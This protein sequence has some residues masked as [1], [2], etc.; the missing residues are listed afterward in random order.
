M[1][2]FKE[3]IE[4]TYEVLGKENISCLISL[5]NEIDGKPP[6]VNKKRYR[7][8]NPDQIPILDYLEQ[9]AHLITT[10]TIETNQFYHLRPYAIPLIKEQKAQKL[11]KLM[12]Q[13]YESFAVFYK[14]RLDASV[15]RDEILKAVNMP[16]E[17]ALEALSYF[18]DTHS[19]WGGWGKGFPY[20]EGSHIN[21]SEGV[22]LKE[23]FL[24]ILTDYYRWHFI[25][26]NDENSKEHIKK[27]ISPPK[28]KIEDK[29]TGRPSLKEK[30][31]AAYEFLKKED[32]IDYSKTLK[33]H[34][35]IIQKTVQALNPEITGTA[36]MAHE[37]IRR[38]I[39]TRF[40]EDKNNL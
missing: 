40:Q 23:S 20:E 21:I 31:I 13:I 26:Q 2:D 14:D 6:C 5:F 3:K 11:L 32:S 22:L 25:N 15:T 37:A 19:V 1:T 29:K 8:N 18:Q 33:S 16:H 10:K 9:S 7:A 35:E 12:C 28:I 38:A 30:I 39:S 27:E 17:E 4:E 34:T 24:E 36:G